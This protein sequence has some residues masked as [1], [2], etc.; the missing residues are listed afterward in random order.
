LGGKL[1]KGGDIDKDCGCM[2]VEFMEVSWMLFLHPCCLTYY[3]FVLLLSNELAEASNTDA[4]N[5][6]SHSSNPY[7]PTLFL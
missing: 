5:Y 7:F 6:F 1:G 3:S 2:S 4:L